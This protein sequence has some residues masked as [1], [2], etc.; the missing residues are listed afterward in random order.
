MTIG[1]YFLDWPRR[2]KEKKM[3]ALGQEVSFI[4]NLPIGISGECSGKVIKIFP[5]RNEHEGPS[6]LIGNV[7]EVIDNIPREMGNYRIDTD[8]DGSVDDGTTILK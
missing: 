5:P 4:V 7:I 2:A 3:F 6:Y 8:P 1:I